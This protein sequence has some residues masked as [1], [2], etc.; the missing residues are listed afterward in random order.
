MG[1]VSRLGDLIESL[2]EL[3]QDATIYAAVPWANESVAIL[4]YE[5]ESGAVPSEASQL[6]LTYFLEVFVAQE[7]LEGWEPTCEKPPTA[8]ERCSRLIRYAVD[9]A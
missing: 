2:S 1:K 6:G 3:D 8:A 9:D 7:F 4:A 5:P